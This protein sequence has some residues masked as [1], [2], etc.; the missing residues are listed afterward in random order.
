MLFTALA[1]QT[2]FDESGRL[3]LAARRNA[4]ARPRQKASTVCWPLAAGE[5]V[6]FVAAHSGHL[7]ATGG[8]V[9]LTYSSTGRLDA[10]GNVDTTRAHP[11]RITGDFGLAPGEQFAL[12][13]GETVVL[14]A[15]CATARI[16]LQWH[17]DG[18]S[19][20]A[21][22]NTSR[23]WTS[24]LARLLRRILHRS[25]AGPA[26]IGMDARQAAQAR[27]FEAAASD[28]STQFRLY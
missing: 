13:A 17:V 7:R 15:W 11:D 24:Q 8:P 5:A 10:A 18:G 20:S 25:G 2:C 14:Q 22:I 16:S 1:S 27:P 28:P 12:A 6:T 9:W 19:D 26:T 4:D 23:H 21:E 3:S